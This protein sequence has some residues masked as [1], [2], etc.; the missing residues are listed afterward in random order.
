MGRMGHDPSGI[1]GRTGSSSLR[2]QPQLD[3]QVLV[4]PLIHGDLPRHLDGAAARRGRGRGDGLAVIALVENETRRLADRPRKD[5]GRPRRDE[6]FRQAPLGIEGR[7]DVINRLVR[8]LTGGGRPEARGDRVLLGGGLNR[9]AVGKTTISRSGRPPPLA[10]PAL[11]SLVACT[12]AL[13]RAILRLGGA[14]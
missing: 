5:R 8:K 7:I 6:V 11:T 1:L 13:R 4:V 10:P 2:L 9:S 14:R 3:L 12:G